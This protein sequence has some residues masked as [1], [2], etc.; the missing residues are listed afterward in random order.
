MPEKRNEREWER[1]RE[2][3]GEIW[4]SKR[5]GNGVWIRQERGRYIPQRSVRSRSEKKVSRRVPRESVHS[6][7]FHQFIALYPLHCVV[8]GILVLNTLTRRLLCRWGQLHVGSLVQGGT[9]S[10]LSLFLLSVM[11]TTG[12]I[13]KNSMTHSYSQLHTSHIAVIRRRLSVQQ[14]R[15]RMKAKT[16]NN[17][18]YT[19]PTRNFAPIQ[20]SNWVS[21]WAIVIRVVSYMKSL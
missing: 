4:A 17:G 19:H 7:S 14:K 13:D 11:Q 8:V 1:E 18:G 5:G 12:L 20:C 3:F 10:D 21:F 9:T 15:T 2:Y 16:R 6:V